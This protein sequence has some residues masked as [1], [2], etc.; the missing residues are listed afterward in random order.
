MPKPGK[1][2][3]A[4]P[5][6]LFLSE[7]GR[8]GAELGLYLATRPLRPSLPVGDGQPVLLLPGLMADD[9]TF[10]PL[11]RVLYSLGYRVHGWQLGRNIGPTFAAVRGMEMRIDELADRYGRPVSLI[12][13]S[14]GGVYARSMARRR[15]EHVR[16]VIT[17]GSPIRMTHRGQTRATSTFERFAHLHVE[18]AEY[19]L[20]SG[21]EPLTAPATSIYSRSDGIVHWQ[22]CLDLPG[23]NAENIAIHSSHLGLGH[24]P[25]AIWA[26]ADRLAQPEHEWVPFRPP[27]VLRPL[28]PRPDQP[29]T[30]SAERPESAAVA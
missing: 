6:S 5:L 13:W 2:R 8:A 19:P 17:L 28:F 1:R 9:A 3:E 22:A 4:P 12:G 7:P 21:L 18:K 15:P 23:P 11:R 16:Q 10:L 24:N 26:V 25:A 27:P 20:E 29:A 30:P 14:L